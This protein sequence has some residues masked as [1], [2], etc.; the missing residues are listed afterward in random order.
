MS[1]QDYQESKRLESHYS[2]RALI[3]AA[4]R[5]ADIDEAARLK[6]A[7]PDVWDE[8]AARFRAPRG[9]LPDETLKALAGG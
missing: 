7:F 6:A 2:F 3:M 5:R 9:L 1:W 4:M 8:Y